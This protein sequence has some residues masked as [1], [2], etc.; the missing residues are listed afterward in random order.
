M[1]Q[2][3]IIHLISDHDNIGDAVTWC[4]EQFVPTTEEFAKATCLTCLRV[5]KIYGEGAAARL[6]HLEANGGQRC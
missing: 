4:Q 3:K 5:I 2:Q 6:Q 1:N